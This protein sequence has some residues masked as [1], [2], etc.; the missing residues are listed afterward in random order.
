[1][2]LPAAGRRVSPDEYGKAA[3]KTNDGFGERSCDK[4]F[5]L[6]RVILRC[7]AVYHTRYADN[8]DEHYDPFWQLAWHPA[9]GKV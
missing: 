9:S 3:L 5:A 4:E 6:G 7:N 1:M 8:P 2:Q